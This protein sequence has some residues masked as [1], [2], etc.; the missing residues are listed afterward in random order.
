MKKH[1]PRP[2]KKKKLRKK[3]KGFQDHSLRPGSG[4]V[5]ADKLWTGIKRAQP[6]HRERTI[7]EIWD[8]SERTTMF[9]PYYTP[10]EVMARKND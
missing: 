5:L 4:S 1:S 10:A 3:P 6:G 8:R 7:G 2:Q 9:T